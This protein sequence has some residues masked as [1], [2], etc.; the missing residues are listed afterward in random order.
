MF[1]I[2]GLSWERACPPKVSGKKA[3][4]SY[5]LSETYFI[6]PGLKKKILPFLL[7]ERNL[8]LLWSGVEGPASLGQPVGCPPPAALGD[9]GRWQVVAGPLSMPRGGQHY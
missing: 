7:W 3:G 4:Y 8:V 2:I 9:G 6:L 1:F 5:C